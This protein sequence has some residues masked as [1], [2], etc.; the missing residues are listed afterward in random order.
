MVCF[1]PLSHIT[2]LIFLQFSCHLCSSQR[3]HFLNF[4]QISNA[5]TL[6]L[7]S[8]VD[9]SCSFSVTYVIVVELLTMILLRSV[10][11][12][13]CQIFHIS[14][15]PKRLSL[16]K[17]AFYT[18][19]EGHHHHLMLVVHIL[20]CTHIYLPKL[21]PW[22]ANIHRGTAKIEMWPIEY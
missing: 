19:S 15:Y 2:A 10:Q 5:E 21:K 6:A 1:L 11:Y 14:Y 9:C 7:K 16:M 8:A 18:L 12:K 20:C 17:L 22:E 4:A 3:K 13:V